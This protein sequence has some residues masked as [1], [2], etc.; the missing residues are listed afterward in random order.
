MPRYSNSDEE[1]ETVAPPLTFAS[2]DP[3][4]YE[5]LVRHLVADAKTGDRVDGSTVLAS[6]FTDPALIRN[7]TLLRNLTRIAEPKIPCQVRIS[8]GRVFPPRFDSRTNSYSI[9]VTFNRLVGKI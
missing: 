1:D 3:E 5:H 9:K 4:I 6:V 2:A 7:P 8:R